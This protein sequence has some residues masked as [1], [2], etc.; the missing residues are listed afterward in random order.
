MELDTISESLKTTEALQREGEEERK[1]VRKELAEGNSRTEQL[2][3][4]G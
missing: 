2:K 1:K 3:V 4:S